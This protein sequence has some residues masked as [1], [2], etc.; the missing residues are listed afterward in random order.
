LFLDEHLGPDRIDKLHL[1][2]AGRL[3][4]GGV[5]QLQTF[6]SQFLASKKD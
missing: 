4:Y 5:S 2:G 6:L 1:F 3:F